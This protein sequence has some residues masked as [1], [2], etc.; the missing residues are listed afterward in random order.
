MLVEKI[1]KLDEEDA[2]ACKKWRDTPADKDGICGQRQNVHNRIYQLA[3]SYIA[4]LE[5]GEPYRH[6]EKEI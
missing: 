4:N 1:A 3:K 2:K 6:L 5:A